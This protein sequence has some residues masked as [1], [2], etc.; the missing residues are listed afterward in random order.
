MIKLPLSNMPD[1][2]GNLTHGKPVILH[3]LFQILPGEE[4]FSSIKPLA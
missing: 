1:P 2:V 3:I 4:Y